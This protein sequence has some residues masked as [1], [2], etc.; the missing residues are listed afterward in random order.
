MGA[1][2]VS[3][4]IPTYNYAQYIG[5]ALRSACEQTFRNI[6]IIVID[7][8][9]TDDTVSLVEAVAA[10]EPRLRLVRNPR[11]LGLQANYNRCIEVA[12]AEYV[13]ILCADDL[14]APDCV[15]RMVAVLEAHTEVSLVACG[16][17]FVGA[18]REHRRV[19]RYASELVIEPGSQ[20]LR[21]C[22]F[23]GNR[24]GEPTAVMFR[25]S[26]AGR[27]FDEAY[28][29]ILDLELW[30]RIIADDWFAAL[31][32]ALCQFRQH[33]GRAT[34]KQMDTGLIAADR[35]R[36]FRDYHAH[37][38]LNPSRLGERLLWDARMAW[39]LGREPT[40][41]RNYLNTGAHHAVYFPSLLS[42]LVALGRLTTA[43]GF[44][45][46]RS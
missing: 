35:V 10:D 20:T 16:R 42:P 22:F 1:P 6:E 18:D 24:I 5:E 32:E 14:L 12:E 3:I 44:G 39:V 9:S 19:D 15:E 26:K 28:K 8:A 29:Q 23:M 40:T 13:K 45:P 4:C 41:A 34:F 27:G 46:A 21:R 7:D 2:R 38:A 37:P 36:L 31:P 11:N 30:L 17:E 43:M 33:L 25:R